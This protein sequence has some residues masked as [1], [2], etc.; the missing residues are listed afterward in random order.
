MI[1]TTARS[2]NRG[3]ASEEPLKSNI[4]IG[5]SKVINLFTSYEIY[6]YA[7]NLFEMLRRFGEYERS[8]EIK[9]MWE[10]KKYS[11]FWETT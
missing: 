6:T 8:D 2:S 5:I 1:W 3:Q 11:G 4:S 10:P 9:T 7:G